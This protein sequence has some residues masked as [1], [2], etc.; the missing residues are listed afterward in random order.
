ML[1]LYETLTTRIP[2][3]FPSFSYIIDKKHCTINA[4]DYL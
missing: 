2:G 4:P 1:K 3:R